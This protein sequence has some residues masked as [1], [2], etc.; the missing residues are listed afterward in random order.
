MKVLVYGS[1][2][3]IFLPSVGNNE[4]TPDEITCVNEII[5]GAMAS[6]PLAR[7]VFPAVR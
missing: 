2:N 1:I 4:I 3:A 6:V 7:E 5:P